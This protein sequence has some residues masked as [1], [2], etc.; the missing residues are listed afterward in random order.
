MYEDKKVAVIIPCYKVTKHILGVIEKIPALVDL[1]VCVD[2]ACPEKCTQLIGHN[3]QD[4]RVKTLINDVNLGVGG[5]VMRGYE[6]ALNENCDILVK[7]DG[8]G[9]MDPALLEY[10]L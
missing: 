4:S 3:K 5:A 10:F 9:Q 6:Y 1:I 2:D 7:I 8:D